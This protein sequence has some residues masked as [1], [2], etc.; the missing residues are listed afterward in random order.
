MPLEAIDNLILRGLQKKLADDDG[1]ARKT[2][3]LTMSQAKSVMKSA[4][5]V[6]AI[7]RD[8]TL[9]LKAPKVRNDEDEDEDDRAVG[10]DDVPS[11]G[12]VL[13]ILAAAPPAFRAVIA[14]GVNGLR[15]GEVMGMSQRQILFDDHRLVIDQQLQRI[16]NSSG[17]WENRLTLPKRGKKRTIALPQAISFVLRRHIEGYPPTDDEWGG[18][19]FRGGRGALMRRTYIYDQCWRP[20]LVGAGLAEDRFVF[21]SLR[22]FAASA[23]LADSA[24]IAAVAAQL[25]DTVETVQRTYVHWLREDEDVPAQVLDRALAPVIEEGAQGSETE[26]GTN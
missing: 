23:M 10:P 20:A 25:G 9:G 21:H 12:D 4:H 17:V 2:V 15:V 3:I 19:L 5:A 8:P 18:M 1:Y 11:R 6:G 13:G 24:P 16:K 7:K 22:H 26:N 14:L